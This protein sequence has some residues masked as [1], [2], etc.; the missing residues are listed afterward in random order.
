MRERERLKTWCLM[1]QSLSHRWREGERER[2]KGGREG[3][4]GR[5]G[6]RV[7]ESERSSRPGAV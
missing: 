7:R 2:R 4:K 5:E 6:E 3:K 1:S